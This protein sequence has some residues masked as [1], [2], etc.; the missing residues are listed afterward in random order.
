M[1]KVATTYWDNNISLPRRA[2]DSRSVKNR[3][4][5]QV[6]RVNTTTPQW[7]VFTV[8]VSITFMLCLTVNLRAFSELN[9]EIDQHGKLSTEV[10]QLTNENL[11]LQEEIH[12]LKTDS[13]RIEREARKLGMSRAGEKILVPAN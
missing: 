11:T 5:S 12:A 3:A 10:D 4:Q 9:A 7:F 8:I 6:K 13:S 1:S 2:A